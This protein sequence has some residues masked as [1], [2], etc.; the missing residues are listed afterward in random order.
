MQVCNRCGILIRGNKQCCPLCEGDLTG[1]PENPAFP[2]IPEKKVTRLSILRVAV[3]LCVIFEVVML[4]ARVLAGERAGWVPTAMLLGLI[5]L[6]DVFLVVYHRNSLLKL[7]TF[8]T[9]VA[10]LVCYYVDRRT[11]FHGWSVSWVIP[12]AFAV[13]AAATLIC[14]FFMHL[15]LTEFSIYLGFDILLSLLQIIF[16]VL[17]MNRF[18][19]PA[20][21][22]MALMVI[23]G[24][25]GLIF[26]T[27]EVKDSA[28]RYFN[29]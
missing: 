28:A 5:A 22:C 2:V 15:K 18:V 1:E 27:R 17:D 16:I 21:I 13:L 29:V 19:W 6:A 11:R 8:Q 25:A 7:I 9:Y 14:A 20:V 24:A 3:F 10:M 26:H 12:C 4:S 23:L